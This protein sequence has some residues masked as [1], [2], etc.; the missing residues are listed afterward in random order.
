MLLRSGRLDVTALA[1]LINAKQTDESGADGPRIFFR[2]PYMQFFLG[3]SGY[4]SKV[5]FDP[6]MMVHFR[7]RFSDE[8]L[9]HINEL[10]VQ[11]GKEMLIEAAA[12]QSHD[13]DDSSGDGKDD[14]DQLSLDS[15]IKPADWP[16]GKNW[17]TLRVAPLRVV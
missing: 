1:S 17:G 13:D 6:S 8:G 15:L 5:P 11:R 2:S 12:S 9:R 4:S 3:F 14:G 16:E 10:V 7:K